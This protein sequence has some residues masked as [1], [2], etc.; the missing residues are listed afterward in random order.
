MIWRLFWTGKNLK[1]SDIFESN[2]NR[3]RDDF[4]AVIN[5]VIKNGI[6]KECIIYELFVF[7]FND[8]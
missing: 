1:Q 6:C 3:V 2:G 8:F 7:F 5:K 4:F